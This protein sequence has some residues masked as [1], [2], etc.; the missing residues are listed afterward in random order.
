[1]HQ[2]TILEL[3]VGQLSHIFEVSLQVDDPLAK[4][5]T[6]VINGVIDGAIL[7]ITL[8][9]LTMHWSLRVNGLLHIHRAP[10]GCP[11]HISR[12]ERLL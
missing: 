11:V 12:L 3:L 9:N 6:Q 5:L 4:C 7:H 1:M 2:Q 8:Q 10:I